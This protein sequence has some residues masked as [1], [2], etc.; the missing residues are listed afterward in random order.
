MVTDV[1]TTVL[2]ITVPSLIKRFYVKATALLQRG[3]VQSVTEGCREGDVQSGQKQVVVDSS[4][5]ALTKNQRDFDAVDTCTILRTVNIIR[6]ICTALYLPQ[7]YRGLTI[8]IH[9]YFHEHSE[10]FSFHQ[11]HAE[12][13]I[14]CNFLCLFLFLY[15]CV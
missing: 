6:R 11:I 12:K 15:F 9:T 7:L 8:F 2:K 3:S 10:P 4:E 13:L 5:Q 1:P 14:P